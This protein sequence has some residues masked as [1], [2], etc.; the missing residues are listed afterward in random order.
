VAADIINFKNYGGMKNNCH[1]WNIDGRLRA[2]AKTDNEGAFIQGFLC[3]LAADVVAHNHFIPF[4]K[5]RLL[6]PAFLGH[7]YWEA[8][9]DA[10]VDDEEWD[11]LADLRHDKQLHRNDR[12]VWQ[13]VPR[14]ALGSHSN[15]WIF[16]NI[17]LLNLRRSWRELIRLARLRRGRYPIDAEFFRHC[18]AGCLKNMMDVFDDDRL[19]L[20][21]LRDPTGRAAL[22]ASRLLRRELVLKHGPG[23]EGRRISLRMAREAY[24]V[25]K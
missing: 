1:N 2:L 8:L 23:E 10:C 15:K 14:R 5:V 13:A 6:P 3:H 19:V 9:A 17:L 25:L 11:L 24:W 22:R 16:N 20:L 4:H 7:A 18:L 12:L 21:K